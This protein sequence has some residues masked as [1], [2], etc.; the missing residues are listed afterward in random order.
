M[1]RFDAHSFAVP[2][3]EWQVRDLKNKVQ[4]MGQKISCELVNVDNIVLFLTTELL[5]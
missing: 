2:W 4:D 5:F 3:E 1:L